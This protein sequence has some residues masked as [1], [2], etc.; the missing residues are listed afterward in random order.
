MVT[1]SARS[2]YGIPQNA[3]HCPLLSLKVHNNARGRYWLPRFKVAEICSLLKF[4]AE[5]KRSS[6]VFIHTNVPLF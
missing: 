4:N 2:I 3:W 1:P 6:A 5:L